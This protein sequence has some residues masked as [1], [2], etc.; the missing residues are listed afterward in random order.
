MKYG[1]FFLAGLILCSCSVLKKSTEL[2]A[3]H[4]VQSISEPTNIDPL[5]VNAAPVDDTVIIGGYRT[6]YRLS[7]PSMTYL[8][9][10]G[11][12]R[13]ADLS[14]IEQLVHMEILNLY[15]WETSDIDF[16]PLKS[17]PE[18]RYIYIRGSA[19]TEIPD[20]GGI[21]SL[22]YLELVNN[23]LT[24]LNGLEKIPQ[25]EKLYIQDARVPMTDTSALR[26]LKSLQRFYIYNSSFNIDFI[27]LADL[28]DLAEIYFSTYGELDLTGIGQL[29]QLKGL[30]LVIRVSE[31]TG[32]QGAFRNI[33]EIGRMTGLTELYLDEAITSVEFLENNVNLERLELIAGKE[34]LPGAV[35][36]TGPSLPL[37]VAP[38]GN[39][40]KLKYLA[41]R[42]F[43][44]I[45][46]HVLASLPEL[47]IVNTALSDPE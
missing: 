36:Y 40:K 27:D 28:P 23:R 16:S 26:Y 11:K 42:G 22:V 33:Q 14:G 32:V 20:L 10:I 43:E 3:G 19:L 37:D 47:E 41:I 25:L 35:Y 12:E 8:I 30:R 21:P 9:T 7:R 2:P 17:L 18:L 44:L 38:L 1:C 15:L 39:L 24:S 45:N 13:C 4:S 46:A 31:E 5:P 34:R 29:R 6:N